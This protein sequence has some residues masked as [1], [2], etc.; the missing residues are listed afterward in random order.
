MEERMTF[1]EAV[2]YAGAWYKAFIKQKPTP[3]WYPFMPMD[4]LDDY[5]KRFVSTDMPNGF[6]DLLGRAYMRDGMG[7]QFQQFCNE[8][9]AKARQRVADYHNAVRQFGPQPIHEGLQK[10]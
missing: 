7:P 2:G 10:W 1:K 6:A 4:A 3:D 9:K 5:L 8:W